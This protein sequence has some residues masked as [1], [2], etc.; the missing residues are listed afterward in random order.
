MD[1]NFSLFRTLQFLACVGLFWYWGGFD[2]PIDPDRVING[3]PVGHS[4][5][6]AH[7]LFLCGAGSFALMDH[8]VGDRSHN[9][10]PIYILL[11]SGMMVAAVIW[12]NRLSTAL[13][14]PPG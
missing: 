12:L 1:L 8:F 4:W 5:I 14:A 6:M 11:G 10:R 7:L 9:L 3:R 2:Y 13:G